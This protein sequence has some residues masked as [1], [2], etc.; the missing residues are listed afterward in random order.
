MPVIR[1]SSASLVLASI[2]FAFVLA[3]SVRRASAELPQLGSQ[4]WIEPGQTK[5]QID[6]YFRTLEEVHMPVARL[7]IMWTYIEPKPGLWDFSLYDQAFASA[8]AHHVRIVATL[9]PSGP[10]PFLHGDGTQGLGVVGSEVGRQEARVYLAKVV[11]RYRNSSALDTWL[12]LNEPGQVA[13][14]QPLAV[15]GYRL[16]L[17]RHYKNVDMMNARWGTAYSEF[18]EVNPSE[19]V[20]DWNQNSAI[21]WMTFWAEYQTDQ[22]AWLAAEVR[23]LD[24]LHPLH[25]N[26]HALI[27]NIATLSDDLPAWRPF[28]D[29]LG[30]SIH[31]GWHFTLLPRDRYAL[32]VSY[33]NDLVSGSI[34]PKPYW[35]TELQGGTNI[36]SATRPIDPSGEEVAQWVWTSLGAGAERIIFWLLNARREGAEAGEWSLLDFQGQPSERL[37]VASS[38]ANVLDQH[39]DFFS[40]AKATRAP[41]TLILDMATMRLEARYAKKDSPSRDANAHLLEALG[42]YKSIAATG[43]PPEIRHFE[44]FDWT[45]RTNTPRTAILPDVRSLSREQIDALVQFVSNGNTLLLTGLTGFYDPHALA[46]PMEHFPLSRLTGAEL[47]EVKWQEGVPAVTLDDS[48]HPLPA[49]S[50]LS[51]VHVLD[52]RPIAHAGREITATVRQSKSGGEVIWIP[53]PVGMGAWFHDAQ[54]LSGFLA[55]TLLRGAESTAFHL[56]GDGSSCILRVLQNGPQTV[57]VVANGALRAAD[58]T[59]LAP[60]SLHAKASLWGAQP[61]LKAGRYVYSL[62]AEGTAVTFWT[63]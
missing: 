22:L 44:D 28:L 10:P 39:K 1:R 21:D 7:F 5:E 4:I 54:P 49:E 47:K 30:C 17:E 58:C 51:T 8:E 45:T 46:W 56:D 36:A 2:L 32:G 19:G 25:L 6:G 60:S 33:I 20:S 31:P 16:W 13:S 3:T 35:V 62:G 42:L 15:A 61:R 57:T 55:Q 52:A 34:A 53:S 14:S 40:G 37:K 11:G 50:W 59:L 27:S 29:S 43:L 12:L 38:I 9:T 63:R 24:L 48:T 26:P 41:V 18:E 23:K